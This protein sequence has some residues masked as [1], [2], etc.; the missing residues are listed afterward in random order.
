MLV[1]CHS[2]YGAGSCRCARSTMAWMWASFLIREKAIAMLVASTT[3]ALPM[4]VRSASGGSTP[5]SVSSMD[6][7]QFSTAS[8]DRKLC[9]SVHLEKNSVTKPRKA[10]PILD[11]TPRGSPTGS[12]AHF[13]LP[14]VMTLLAQTLSSVSVPSLERFAGFAAPSSPSSLWPFFLDS[15]PVVSP[16]NGDGLPSAWSAP[17]DSPAALS[18]FSASENFGTSIRDA[19]RASRSFSATSREVYPRRPLLDRHTE[20]MNR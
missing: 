14:S 4:V 18:L 17:P 20:S 8:G 10:L 5:S 19:F 1:R 11:V 3:A 16:F 13:E 12:S 6:R 7:W 9:A 2:S 15:S